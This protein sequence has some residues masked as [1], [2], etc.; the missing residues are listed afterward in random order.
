MVFTAAA[1]LALTLLTAGCS[2]PRGVEGA[3]GT[4]LE[5]GTVYSADLD[6]DGA[7]EQ[8]LID[9]TSASLTITDGGTVYRSRDKWQVV[10]AYLGDTDRNGLL[11]VVALL[12]SVDGRHLGL[13]AYFGGEY[14]ERF[15]TSPLS[16]R[17]LSLEVVDSG[18]TVEGSAGEPALVGD[19]LSLTVEPAPGQTEEQTVLCRWNGFGFTGVESS[20]SD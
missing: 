4:K 11:E 12:D 9:E 10:E 14:R 3:S 2:D 6:G 18:Q 20:P 7:P 8:V 13:F 16:P 1:L 15:V 5:P 17:P 19:V